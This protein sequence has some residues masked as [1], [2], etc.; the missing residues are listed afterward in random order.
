MYNFKLQPGES[1]GIHAWEFSGVML[2]LSDGGGCLEGDRGDG[3]VFGGSELSRVGGW[4]WVDG[5]VD[6]NARNAGGSVYE[7]VVVEWL[8]EG[9]PVEGAS[10][11]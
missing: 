4:K 5:P 7:A 1:T 2:C 3:G 9:E 8:G 10:R 6:V 11:L